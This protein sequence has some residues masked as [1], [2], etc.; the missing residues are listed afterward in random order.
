MSHRLNII[1]T[2]FPLPL[3]EL[4]PSVQDNLSNPSQPLRCATL[5][6]LCCFS[7]PLLP[8]PAA[9]ADAAAAAR[10]AG[11]GA[12][13]AAAASDVFSPWL[14]LSSGMLSVENGRAA[15]VAVGKMK[16]DVEFGR[17]PETLLGAFVE[18][19]LG[20]LY[21]R[22]VFQGLGLGLISGTGLAGVFVGA[23]LGTYLI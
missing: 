3:Q 20:G 21:I 16:T 17:V 22:W 19:L 9:D 23:F 4:L 1:F 14:R 2:L 8:R 10:S 6:L 7:Q 11:A 12:T 5:R 15:A 18:C 13:A